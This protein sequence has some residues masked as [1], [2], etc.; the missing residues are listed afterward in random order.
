MSAAWKTM[1]T[2]PDVN[3]FCFFLV[4]NTSVFDKSKYHV[5][6]GYLTKDGKWYDLSSLSYRQTEDVLY[7]M[8]LP[9]AEEMLPCQ[10]VLPKLFDTVIVR[11]ESGETTQAQFLKDWDNETES[12][13]GAARWVFTSALGEPSFINVTHW[14]RIPA[15]P[16]NK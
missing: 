9:P 1:G 4:R 8:P 6:R 14:V 3:D 12:Y 16:Q 11:T 7:W 15:M 2:K 10:E 13:S 5:A